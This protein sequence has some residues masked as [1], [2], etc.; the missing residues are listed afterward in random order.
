MGKS[1]LRVIVNADD[2]GLNETVNAAIEKCIK[3]GLIT[4]TTI[5][6]AGEGFDDAVTLAKKYPYISYGVHLTLDELSSLTKSPVLHK[7]GMTDSEGL[8]IKGGV[9]RV[10]EWTHELTTAIHYELEAQIDKIISAGLTPSHFDGH[11]H[12]H[13][14]KYLH[15]IMVELTRKYNIT[16][17]RV[18]LDARDMDMILHH[19]TPAISKRTVT[20]SILPSKK[21]SNGI[22]KRVRLNFSMICNDRFFKRSFNT[23]DYC[24]SVASFK[25]NEEYLKTHFRGKTIELMCHPGHPNYKEETELLATIPNSVKMTSYLSL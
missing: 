1:E 24:C 9:F 6:A 15:G 3:Q 25:K 4:S 5:M 19:I 13:T 8:F 10:Q 7:Y 23:T 12:C 11:H 2:F 22:I 14:V 20:N 17:V 18:P 21:S 16:K